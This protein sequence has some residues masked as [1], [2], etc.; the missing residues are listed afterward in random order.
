METISV[1]EMTMRTR[2][3]AWFSV[4]VAASVAARAES[5]APTK[6][7]GA[8][9][10]AIA[11]AA[12]RAWTITDLVLEKD[13]DPPARQ[14]MLLHGIKALLRQEKGKAPANLATRASAVTTLEH[15]TTLLAEVWPADKDDAKPDNER[16]E[17]VLFGGLL[18]WRMANERHGFYL[19]PQQVKRHERDAGN[20]YVGTGIQIRHNDKEKLAQIVI[21]FP[22]GPA[23]KAGARPG[24]L[25][26]EVDG[27]SMEGLSLFKVVERLQGEEGTKVS[28]TVRQPGETKT[29]RLPMVRA[30]IPFTSVHGYR[31]TGEES[32]SFSVDLKSAI[33][34]LS[35]DDI[36]IS[37]PQELR[38]IEPLVRA[39]EAKALVLDLRFTT[40]QDIR[41]AALVADC[42]LDGGLLWRVRDS[43]G[44][45]KEYKADR[46]CVFRD[47]PTVVLVGEYTGSMGALVAAALQDR[48][49]AVVVGEVPKAEL[50][51]TSLVPLPEEGGGL[52]LRT[53]RVERIERAAASERQRL[54]AAANRL[55]P[56]RVVTIERKEMEAVL[57]WRAHV[58]DAA[59]VGRGH[60]DA[61]RRHPLGQRHHQ[62][63][64]F[65][66]PGRRVEAGR[67]FVASQ[68][69]AAV[70][71]V[72]PRRR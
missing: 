7:D 57:A 15:F 12:R 14:E 33:G 65:A 63:R 54:A 30:V 29:R 35:I 48:G 23:R 1:K 64:A 45:V 37:T 24:D 27:K 26:V 56:D 67:G 43:G 25:I 39:E 19:S 21:P 20:R 16:R 59:G 10:A 47:V 72:W 2:N 49:R 5:P 11:A 28:M 66:V 58:P 62:R 36:K 3:L 32:W 50:A 6:D 4:M 18:G 61:D 41:H 68:S 17:H 52:M 60:A 9:A 69:L 34:Y 31:R 53:G 44:R 42:L 13:I 55:L 70:G 71:R 51:F 22:G 40:G 46:D 38:K 8:R